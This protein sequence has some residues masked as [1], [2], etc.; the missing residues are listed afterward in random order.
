MV[1]WVDK[2]RAEV[3]LWQKRWQGNHH[4]LPPVLFFKKKGESNVVHDSRAGEIVEHQVSELDRQLL[5]RLTS[6]KS[7][8]NLASDL[9]H[10]SKAEIEKTIGSLQERGL[11]FREGDR[12]ISLVF[13]EEPQQAY[14]FMKNSVPVQNL[15]KIANEHEKPLLVRVSRE[16]HRLQPLSQ[17]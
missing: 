8:A 3:D 2:I 5:E 4:A 7:I 6:S 13:D 9:S 14:K 12:F 1:K 15:K 11:V 16:L 17:K 10:I